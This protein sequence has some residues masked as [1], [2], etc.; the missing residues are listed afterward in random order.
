MCALFSLCSELSYRCLELWE[1][2]QRDG[3][4][5]RACESVRQT[6][7]F[8]GADAREKEVGEFLLL[9]DVLDF[10]ASTRA[11][12]NRQSRF[13]YLWSE[14]LRIAVSVSTDSR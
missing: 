10:L 6:A 7:S 2:D 8:I 13:N 9:N 12:R 3:R 1:T 11:L 5:R 4:G 14:H